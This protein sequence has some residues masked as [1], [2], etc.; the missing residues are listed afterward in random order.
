MSIAT[1]KI[2]PKLAEDEGDYETWRKDI[3]IW[4]EFTDLAVE[5]RALAIHLSLTGKAR[6]ASSELTVAQLKHADGVKT[7]LEKLDELFLQDKGRRQFSLFR[8]LYNLRRDE[9]VKINDFVAEFEHISHKLTNININIPDS[10]LA[11]LLLASLNLPEKDVQIIM[12]GMTDVTF[13]IMKAT[14]K[15]VFGSSINNNVCNSNIKTEPVFEATET[16]Y[17]GGAGFSQRGRGTSAGNWRGVNGSRGRYL[18]GRNL[19]TMQS[20][21]G[22][23]QNPFDK[24]GNVSLCRIC[25]S[26]FHWANKCPDAYENRNDINC[27]S[28][29]NNNQENNNDDTAEVH[30]S[31]FIGFT[32]GEKNKQ[33]KLG[34][35]VN[36]SA[37]CA[38]LDS[39][40]TK[41]VCGVEW[42]NNY[43]SNLSEFDKKCIKENPS[44][45]SFT[46]GDST[47]ERSLKRVSM[48]CYIGGKRSLIESDIVSSNIP[49]LLS[50]ASMKRGKMCLDFGNDMLSVGHDDISLKCSS[51]GHYLL[52]LSL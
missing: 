34:K 48:P 4:C 12:S 32:S 35:L 7:L 23:K 28:E 27:V 37:C 29:N 17:F 31:L 38:L 9:S 26:K 30:L 43:V 3:N 25:N 51:S 14:I 18:R 1:N 42:F 21:G 13:D 40:C 33:D 6:T 36:D 47:S 2:P 19:A 8:E 24:H 46:F 5:K 10:V 49:L 15:R 22:R 11:F 39:G 50:K 16:A 20:R 45:S 41:T 52:P 44:L